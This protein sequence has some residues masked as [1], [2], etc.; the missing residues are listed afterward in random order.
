M[1]VISDFPDG[2]EVCDMSNGISGWF[3]FVLNLFSHSQANGTKF[4]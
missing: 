2:I 1:I 3:T 4:S